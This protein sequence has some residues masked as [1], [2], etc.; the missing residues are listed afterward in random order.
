VL[1]RASLTGA[2]VADRWVV[3]HQVNAAGG[4]PIDSARTDAAGHWRLRAARVDTTAIY[5]ASALYAGLAY[6][7]PPL[8]VV[9][10]SS[11]VALPLV[12]YDTSS[13]GPAVHVRRRFVTFARAKT[14]GS[15]EA[16]EILEL[17]NPGRDT[18]IAPDTLQPT[19]AGAIPP[20]VLGFEPQQSDFSAD[21]ILQRGGDVQLFGPVQ[22]DHA[23]QLS[24]RYVVPGTT[25]TLQ[26]PVDQP[27][28]ELDILLEDTL[29][30]VQAP[31]LRVGGVEGV[32]GR[33]FATYRVDS[34][35]A[36]V[37]VSIAFPA[38]RFRI[39]SLLPILIVVIALVLGA[40]LW[41]ALRRSPQP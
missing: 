28:G 35:G 34:L 14:D 15:H 27:I 40:G 10:G 6:F 36:G 23:H 24:Y 25:H 11:T 3:L 8:P 13:T 20:G 4:G 37:T 21:A 7:S 16:L 38:G 9:A 39:E 26:F 32:E 22:P 41:V 5:V 30:V 12:V 2:P 33:R 19:W 31:G 29:A 1:R 17:E 18:R